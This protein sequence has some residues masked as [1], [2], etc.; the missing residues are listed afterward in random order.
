MDNRDSFYVNLHPDYASISRAVLDIVHFYK[1][2]SVTVVYEDA[3]G[4]R[5]FSVIEAIN[6]TFVGVEVVSQTFC[7]GFDWSKIMN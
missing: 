5:G 3:T 7:R 2:K 4:K 1:W 6:D